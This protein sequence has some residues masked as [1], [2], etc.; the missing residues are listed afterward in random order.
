MY[1]LFVNR[2]VDRH[3]FTL[4]FS[5]AFC[6]ANPGAERNEHDQIHIFQDTFFQSC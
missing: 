1:L 2:S 4:V 6:H 3:N 5:N